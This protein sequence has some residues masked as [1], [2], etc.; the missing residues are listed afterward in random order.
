MTIAQELE[1]LGLP[2]LPEPLPR[3]VIDNHTHADETMRVSKLGAE[4][5]LRA[6]AA[7]GVNRI[8]QVGCD[9]ASSR[10]AVELAERDP[11]VVAA[12][13][14]HPNDAARRFLAG[15]E[16]ALE[17][18]LAV[19]EPLVAS[20]VVRAVGETGIDYYRTR[21]ASA[22]EAQEI[23]FRRHIGW[24]KAAGKTLVIH[25]RD[26]HDEIL[27]VLD[28]EGAPER[29]VMHCFSGDADFA[30]RCL[31]RGA[32]LSFPGVTTYPSAPNLREAALVTPLDRLLVETDAPYLT[33]KPVRGR[34]N[35][36]YLLPHTVRFLAE[37]LEVDLAEFCDQITA[38][39][40][41]AFGGKWGDDD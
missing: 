38:N 8:V 4:L 26:A 31:E 14:L 19:I 5:S 17:A 11:R 23:S 1:A 3:P 15:G 7:A 30:E 29:F 37:L 22:R 40:F 6:A 2:G 9:V 16:S 27:R 24:A 33:P 12:V 41:A 32:W 35:A 13:A 39:T 34:P 18:A 10:Y 21:D 20:P 36:P 25:D 28:D